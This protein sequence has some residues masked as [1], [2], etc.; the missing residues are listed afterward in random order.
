MLTNWLIPDV[1]VNYKFLL[2]CYLLLS[3]LSL[4]LYLMQT[5]TSVE[6]IHGFWL[7]PAPAVLMIPFSLY[8]H[9]K[10]HKKS[11]SE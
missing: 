9:M 2:Y 10:Q 5:Y 7:I 8:M 1:S 3:V 11:K 4:S 6:A